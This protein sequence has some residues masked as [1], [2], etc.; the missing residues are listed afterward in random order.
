MG[1]MG[2]GGRKVGGAKEHPCVG[3]CAPGKEGGGARIRSRNWNPFV[4]STVDYDSQKNERTLNKIIILWFSTFI[5]LTF[6]K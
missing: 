6:S 3:L 5:A 2:G 1:Q 4:N